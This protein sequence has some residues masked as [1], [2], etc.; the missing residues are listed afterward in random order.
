MGSMII[1]YQKVIIKY[2][3]FKLQDIKND[4]DNQNTKIDGNPLEPIGL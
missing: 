2:E 3:F 1:L 4:N